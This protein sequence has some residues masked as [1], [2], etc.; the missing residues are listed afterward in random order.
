MQKLYDHLGLS[1]FDR[2]RP[3]IESYLAS[4]ADYTTNRYDLT[5]PQ[6]LEIERRWG[7][8]IRRYGY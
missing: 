6:R 7:D 4:I 3:R 8:V 1:K 5:P 2:V